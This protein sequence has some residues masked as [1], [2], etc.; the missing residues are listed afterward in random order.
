MCDV[1]SRRGEP[2]YVDAVEHVADLP[3]EVPTEQT[4]TTTFTPRRST[5]SM[6]GQR[7]EI[8]FQNETFEAILNNPAASHQDQ[9][10]SYHAAL[11]TDHETE[12]FNGSDPQAYPAS[13]KLNDPDMPSVHDALHCESSHQYIEAM[14]LEVSQ[15]IK[16][17]P[18]TR[19]SR[20]NVPTG[21][22]VLK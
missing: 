15:R 20:E 21:K 17:I 10:L 11:H 5:R 6:K 12:E 4:H 8:L 1:D 18:W 9:L 14:K 16:Q 3:Q 19:I 22:K 2:R 7:T 13:H